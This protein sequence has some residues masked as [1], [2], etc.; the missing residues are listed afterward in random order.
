MNYEE[1]ASTSTAKTAVFYV[2]KTVIKAKRRQSI[3][4]LV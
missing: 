2:L 4:F 1:L 3:D